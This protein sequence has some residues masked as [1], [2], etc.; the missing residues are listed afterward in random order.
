[1]GEQPIKPTNKLYGD[2]TKEYDPVNYDDDTAT[3][4]EGGEDDEDKV[5]YW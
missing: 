2:Y 3:Q 5:E 1:M 4:Q